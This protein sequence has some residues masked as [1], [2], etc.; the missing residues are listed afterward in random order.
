LLIKI[1][2][3]TKK[4]TFGFELILNLKFEMQI[5]KVFATSFF[6]IRLSFF[7]IFKCSK[8]FY[9]VYYIYS[10]FNCIHYLTSQEKS[11]RDERLFYNACFVC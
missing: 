8:L 2:K 4:T 1:K 6:Y 10:H 7:F 9:F 5:K 11:R 3:Q